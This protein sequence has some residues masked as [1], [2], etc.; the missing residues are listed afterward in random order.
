MF[1]IP[2]FLFLVRSLFFL[3]LLF[4]LQL[5]SLGGCFFLR[6][7]H[8]PCEFFFTC[9]GFPFARAFVPVCL[10]FKICMRC[11]SLCAFRCD[12]STHTHIFRMWS[13]AFRTTKWKEKK[14]NRYTRLFFSVIV[15]L[16]VVF[17]CI[18]IFFRCCFVI[19]CH[20]RC[21]LVCVFFFWHQHHTRPVV[22]AV[23]LLSSLSLSLYFPL[24]LFW[25]VWT[26]RRIAYPCNLCVLHTRTEHLMCFSWTMSKNE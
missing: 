10:P 1:F 9:F 20:C 5:C 17:I 26:L 7:L 12:L 8:F 19:V 14:A 16:F 23:R 21:L 6:L 15:I 3:L 13:N 18:Y 11:V 22:Y 4:S 25:F 2:R 24:P